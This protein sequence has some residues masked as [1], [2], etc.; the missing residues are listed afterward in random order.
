MTKKQL[1]RMIREEV[2]REV[3]KIL[4]D[5]IEEAMGQVIPKVK[6]LIKES[7]KVQK[8]QTQPQASTP[9]DRTRMKELIGYG[10]FEPGMNRTEPSH[11]LEESHA[12]AAS[13]PPS[14]EIAGVPVEG[15][16]AAREEAAS[17]GMD[18]QAMPPEL[19]KAIAKSKKVLDDVEKRSNWRPGMK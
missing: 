13:G 3:N 8:R 11:Y 18:F 10:D 4:P 12:P 19:Q 14:M 16:L 1:R 2:V 5:V 17:A 6:R 9:I 15:G 7:R